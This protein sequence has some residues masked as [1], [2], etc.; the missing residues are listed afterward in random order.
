[1]SNSFD[2]LPNYI[3][4]NTIYQNNLSKQ[5]NN[6]IN[7]NNFEDYRNRNCRSVNAIT[8]ARLNLILNFFKSKKNLQIRFN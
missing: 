7:G 5:T 6:N 4:T 1:M 2:L 3:E 8:Y